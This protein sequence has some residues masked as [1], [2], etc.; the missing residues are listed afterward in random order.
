V[1]LLVALVA[2][3]SAW[4]VSATSLA[5]TSAV[6]PA[7]ATVST[8][9][10]G[11][12]KKIEAGRWLI[13]QT[14]VVVDSATIV[15][16]RRGKAEV[17]AWVE[18]WAKMGNGRMAGDTIRVLRPAGAPPPQIQFAGGILKMQNGAW[19][20]G[21]KDVT[22]TGSTTVAPS[23]QVGAL[24]RVTGYPQVNGALATLIEVLAPDASAVPVTI[25]GT[26]EKITDG[27]VTVDGNPVF[28]GTEQAG[29]LD[30]GD[31]VEIGALVARDGSLIAITVNTVDRTRDAKLDAYVSSIGSWGED[32]QTWTVVA[33]DGGRVETRRVQVAVHTYVDEDQATT[34]PHIEADIEG[35]RLSDTD[36]QADIVRLSPPSPVETAG[37]L[38]A[39]GGGGWSLDGQPVWFASDESRGQAAVAATAADAAVVVS[40]VRLRSGLIV[41]ES[42][43]SAS[44]ADLQALRA[45]A[46]G[47]AAASG[48]AWV[49]PVSIVDG[50]QKADKPTLLFGPDRT[51]HLI[52]EASS[53]IYYMSQPQG[54]SWSAPQR[55]ARGSSPVA[56]LDAAGTLHVAYVNEFRSNYDIY[57][58]RLA[59]GKWTLPVNISSTTGNSADPAIAV[60]PAGRVYV[61]WM[62]NT[63]GNFAI[64]TGEWDGQYWTSYPVDNGRG[65]NPSLAVLP[66]G[67]LFLAWQDRVPAAADL[68]GKFDIY[69][70]EGAASH[71][72][73][74]VSVSDNAAFSPGAESIG[75]KTI[76]S[77]DGKAHIAWIDDGRQVRYDFGRG[78]YWP[79]PVN[80]GARQDSATGLSLRLGSDDLLYVAWDAGKTGMLASAPRG[81]Q[82]WQRLD[83]LPN[84]PGQCS[85]VSLA[86]A[87]KGFALAWLQKDEGSSDATIY[88]AHYGMARFMLR[89]FIPA[90]LTQ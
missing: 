38:A 90:V 22:I 65:Q 7:S 19:N 79:K 40:G 15:D 24:V 68:V 72:S 85:S 9:F 77:A 5:G 14:F 69:G 82:N 53:A 8:R 36:I 60:S 48:I 28:V 88:E 62:D 66:E 46:L 41:A 59:G 3:L 29:R 21:G 4:P 63:T 73:M 50:L 25:E 75:P 71:W 51:A 64:Q 16:E 44:A 20:V 57:H 45:D 86:L 80:I 83:L 78:M 32:N 6:A 70:S 76:A 23:A 1:S 55:I 26:V 89:S 33:V 58:V 30:Q 27:T 42:V 18:V 43:R 37:R 56:A 47:A 81:A 11:S 34:Q 87:G 61:A 84:L 13:D 2:A 17:G 31:W 12:L 10:E 67:Q 52:Y 49:G 74:P 54:K 39:D 35:T